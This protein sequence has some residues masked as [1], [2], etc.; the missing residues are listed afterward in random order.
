MSTKKEMLEYLAS[1]LENS[2]LGSKLYY[3]DE[4]TARILVGEIKDIKIRNPLV[5]TSYTIIVTRPYIDS[6]EDGTGKEILK[7]DIL[8]FPYFF[9]RRDAEDHLRKVLLKKLNE[10]A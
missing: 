5:G 7:N 3:V 9:S 10:L 2:I 8:H 6:E 4:K 1:G